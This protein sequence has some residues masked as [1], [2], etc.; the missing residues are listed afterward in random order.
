MK[1]QCSGKIGQ[2]FGHKMR[3]R[4]N[5]VFP[6]NVCEIIAKSDLRQR[7]EAYQ[8]KIYLHDICERCGD[9]PEEKK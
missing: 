7:I 4:Y 9:M 1:T 2:L 8:N 5:R 3:P 6:E